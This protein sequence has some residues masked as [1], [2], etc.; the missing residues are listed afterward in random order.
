MYGDDA[1]L[2][3]RALLAG[4]RFETYPAATADIF[5]RRSDAPRITGTGNTPGLLESRL[6]RLTE[7]RK[8]LE[9][10]AATPELLDLWEGQY[11]MEGEFLLFNQPQ[12]QFWLNKLFT[13]WKRDYPHSSLRQKAARLYL[14][15]SAFW[16]DRW[17]LQVRLA[18]KAM[19]QLLPAEWFPVTRSPEAA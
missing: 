3:I 4:L 12:P 9:A 16:R 1:D 10:A 14:R 18:R 15:W 11:F 19:L 13:Q 6:V 2:H 8:A 7:G 17:Y 5:I